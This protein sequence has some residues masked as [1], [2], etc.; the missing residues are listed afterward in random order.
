MFAMRFPQEELE[1]KNLKEMMGMEGRRVRKCYV[2]LAEKYG[3]GWKG[4]VYTPGKFELSNI[5][6]KIIT[7]A[8][9]AL[10]AL[11]LSVVHALGFS[12]HIGFIHSGSPLPFI[13]DL[14]DLYKDKLCID[15][16]F[17]MTLEAAGEYNRELTANEF[18][19]RVIESN[20]L[21]KLPEDIF[22]VIFGIK[23]GSSNSE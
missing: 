11:I 18:R 9:A 4:R 8:N 1:G 22:Y 7:A 13:Y 15:L 21:E 6:N 10:Y 16:A 5:T 3:V 2:E 23:N 17:A 12:P 14:A 20:L 19:R